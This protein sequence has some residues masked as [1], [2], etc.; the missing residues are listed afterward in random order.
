MATKGL[1]NSSSTRLESCVIYI[2]ECTPNKRLCDELHALMSQGNVPHSYD[3]RTL[4][5][6][7]RKSSPQSQW[8]LPLI[9]YTFIILQPT[10]IHY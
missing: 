1:H 7:D 5:H 2:Y 3:L 8:L 6:Y 9:I 4:E 10:R